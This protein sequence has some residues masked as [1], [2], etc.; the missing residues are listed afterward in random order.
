MPLRYSTLAIT[1][2]IFVAYS[3]AVTSGAIFLPAVSS[4]HES[5]IEA[6]LGGREFVSHRA[7]FLVT[8]LLVAFVFWLPVGVYLFACNLLSFIFYFL[9]LIFSGLAGSVPCALG[10]RAC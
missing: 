3:I 5:R 7:I 10:L 4:E 9:S 8:M 2:V 6:F 1:P